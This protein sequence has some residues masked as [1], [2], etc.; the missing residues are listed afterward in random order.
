MTG[1]LPEVSL[2]EIQEQI[3]SAKTQAEAARE[4]RDKDAWDM[5]SGPSPEVKGPLSTASDS[6]P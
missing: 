1:S 3:L 2:E 5:E 6:H 4:E